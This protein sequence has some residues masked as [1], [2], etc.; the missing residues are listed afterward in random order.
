MTEGQGSDT[1][2]ATVYRDAVAGTLE[3]VID[4]QVRALSDDLV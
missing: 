4:A 3:R 1:T 2:M